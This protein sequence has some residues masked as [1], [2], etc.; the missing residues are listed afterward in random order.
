MHFSPLRRHLPLAALALLTL[1]L[2]LIARP[3]PGSA[4]PSATTP[5]NTVVVRMSG[6]MT[7]TL[8]RSF[9]RTVKAAKA[10]VS[11][12]EGATLRGRVITFPVDTSTT[13]SLDPS[14]AEITAKG[15]LMIRKTGG[16]KV[17]AQDVT[18]RLKAGGADVGATLRGRPQRQLAAL[19]LAPTSNVKNAGNAYT[20]TD[21]QMVV[22]GDLAS[23][24]RRAKLKGVKAGALLGLMSAELRADL[25]S[26]TLPGI[27]T[28]GR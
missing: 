26:L 15:L 20:F 18:L 4:V 24:A 5:I 8:D 14:E 10:K 1:A 27:G 13:V 19:T 21:L 17:V 25:P 9:L 11:V 22:S 16:R 28:L 3:A 7:F 23:A 12:K 2:V 6:T